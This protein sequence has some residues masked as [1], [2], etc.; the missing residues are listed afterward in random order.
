MPKILYFGNELVK[1]VD[2]ETI[3]MRVAQKFEAGDFESVQRPGVA[4][5]LSR[6]NRPVDRQTGGLRFFP[7]H[8]M[9]Y[10]PNLSNEDIGHDMNRHNPEQPLPMMAY[11]G[12]HAYMIMISD[13]GTPRSRADLDV[14]CP[15]W[16]FAGH[17]AL[18]ALRR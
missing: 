4:Y 2:V 9:F 11:S 17:G 7:P 1:G 18:A 16:V 15:A 8:V 10:A 14:S 13:D 6:Y 5:M 12:P 3:E